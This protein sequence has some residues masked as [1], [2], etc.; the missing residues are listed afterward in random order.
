MCVC[1]TTFLYF[2]FFF[3]VHVKAFPKALVYM[4]LWFNH[5]T[6]VVNVNSY[7]LFGNYI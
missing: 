3:T 5:V 4:I 6:A 7:A 2:N 1:F